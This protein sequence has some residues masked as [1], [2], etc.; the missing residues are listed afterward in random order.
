[1]YSTCSRGKMVAR[2]YVF[3]LQPWLNTYSAVC[4]PPAAAVK[5]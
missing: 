2:L 3:H 4:I 5:W 1:M